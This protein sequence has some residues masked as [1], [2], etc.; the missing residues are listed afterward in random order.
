MSTLDFLI[1]Y[2]SVLFS[3]LGVVLAL[4]LL[5]APRLLTVWGESVV[6]FLLRGAKLLKIPLGQEPWFP[7]MPLQSSLEANLVK[8]LGGTLPVLVF[9]IMVATA[10]GK[11]V[12]STLGLRPPDIPSSASQPGLIIFVHGWNGDPEKT[13]K[14]FPDLVRQDARLANYGVAEIDYPTY[15]LARN[16]RLADLSN[17]LAGQLRLKGVDQ[18]ERVVFIAHSMGGLISR[19]IVIQSRLAGAQIP[20]VLLI[21]I[22]SPHDGADLARITAAIGVSRDL[23]R[24]VSRDSGFLVGLRQHWNQLDNRPETFC[25]TSPH[26]IVVDPRSATAQCDRESRYPQWSHSDLVKPNG[27]QDTRYYIP[28]DKI[29]SLGAF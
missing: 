13:W 25:V 18:F 12:P 26:D 8:W 4:G 9:L 7:G 19:E 24:D 23:T 20:V 15:M 6:G 22:G 17:W 2:Q 29:L 14:R 21:E 16:L 1:K 27:R 10:V 11:P 3:V 28:V 5:R